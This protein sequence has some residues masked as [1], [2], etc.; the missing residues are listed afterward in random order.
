MSDITN[1]PRGA[2]GGEDVKALGVFMEG[3][4]NID[5][6]LLS[7]PSEEQS[8]DSD[9][10]EMADPVTSIRLTNSQKTLDIPPS[11]IPQVERGM[12][13]RGRPNSYRSRSPPRKGRGGFL[14]S[15]E[16]YS[17]LQRASVLIRQALDVDGV[18]FLDI[19]GSNQGRHGISHAASSNSRSRSPDEMQGAHSAGQVLG[20]SLSRENNKDIVVPVSLLR[21][22][23]Q[24]YGRGGIFHLDEGRLSPWSD[25]STSDIDAS[26]S[27]LEDMAS[28][29]Y[30][31]DMHQLSHTFSEANSIA[32]FPLWD[33]QERRWFAGCFAWIKNYMGL[34]VESK[35]LTYLTAF[36]NSV[37]AEISRL[38]L[39]AADREKADFISSVSHEWRSPLHGILTMLD[40]IKETNVTSV[41][42]HVLDYAKINSLI[43]PTTHNGQPE[44]P[45][46]P[47][48]SHFDAPALINQ[49]NLAV[50]IEEV[51]EALLASQDYLGRNAEA[52]FSATEQ[53][54]D[55][56][57]R[58]SNLRNSVPRVI[59]VI[60]DIQWRENWDYCV[61]AGAWRRVVL[62]LF[63]NALKFTFSRFVQL[64]L[65]HDTLKGGRQNLPA[66][67]IQISD[68]RRGISPDISF[69]DLYIPVQ[70]EDSPSPGIGVG[71]NIV[72]RIV[73]SMRGLI[74]IRSEPDQA[75]E[76]WSAFSC[77]SH[78]LNR[79]PSTSSV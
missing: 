71:L 64:K 20:C 40:I 45:G 76:R 31:I 27:S 57:F 60:V 13:F 48:G 35:D 3:K 32:F 12:P 52:L 10:S 28:T 30:G 11:H 25:E 73:N 23:V 63:G 36:N 74:V 70:Q 65:R 43:E 9:S 75:K 53:T 2:S 46:A 33:F 67:L 15:E 42:R 1:N 72:Y 6:W 8:P 24:R 44:H 56:A 61:S 47:Q 7:G 41:Q 38:D 62:N 54:S 39:R 29:C 17:V 5:E 69:T 16:T 4:S 49:V 55:R 68:S 19:R 50:L 18:A 66:V 37:L 14:A 59:F 21:S 78:Q 77:P 22:L 34:F 58:E 26:S 79:L 51:A